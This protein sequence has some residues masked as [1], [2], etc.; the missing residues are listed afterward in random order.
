MAELLAGTS[1]DAVECAPNESPWSS[2][3]GQRQHLRVEGVDETVLFG[4]DIRTPVAVSA[5]VARL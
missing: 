2:V 1:P 4:T 5:P 3:L